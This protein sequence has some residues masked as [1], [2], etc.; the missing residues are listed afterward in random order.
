MRVTC[1]KNI[2]ATT[3]EAL[4]DD[5]WLTLGQTYVVL[6]VYALPGKSVQYRL[7]GNDGCTPAV[8]DSQQFRITD[9]T[10]FSNWKISV[11]EHNTLRLE[12]A[13]WKRPGFWEEYFDGSEEAQHSFEREK[14]LIIA[15]ARL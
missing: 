10:L 5:N 7:I 11:G 12:P 4:P 8:F 1:V 3:N 14:N 9:D 6:A 13:E 2:S 15:E